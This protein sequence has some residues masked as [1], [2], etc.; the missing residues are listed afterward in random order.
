MLA[1]SATGLIVLGLTRPSAAF[2]TEVEASTDAQFYM[3]RSPYGDPIVRRRRYTQTLGLS[4]YDIQ[5]DAAL[6]GPRLSFRSRMRLDA[7]FGIEGA[8]SNPAR[9]DQFVPGAEQAPIDLMYAYLQ[10]EGYFGGWLGFRLGRQYVTDTLGFWSFDGGLVRL[11][12]PVYFAVEAYGGFE[13]RGGLPISTSRFE[14][15]GVFRGDRSDLE[16]GEYVGYLEESE[17]APALGFAVES[18]GVHFLQTRLSYRRVQNRDTVVVSPFP[19]AG[20]GLTTVGGDRVSSERLGY[21]LRV[22]EASLGAAGGSLVYDFYA[23]IVSEYEGSLDWYANAML[24][25]GAAYEYYEPTFDGDSV[26]N[27]FSHE[28]SSS[29]LGR[30]TLI[31]SR[32]IDVALT[33]GIEQFRTQ[34]DPATYDETAPVLDASTLTDVLGSLTG[35]YRWADGSVTLHAL[36]EAG[37]RGHRAGGDVTTKKLFGGGVYDMLVVSSLYDWSDALRPQRDAASFTYVLGGGMTPF[38]STRFG[39]EWEHTMNRLVGQRFRVLATLDLTVLK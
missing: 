39:V 19:D 34:G 33:G 26:F 14:G 28:G 18:T 7:D 1:G 24:T 11:D 9:R 27:W 6:S 31:F 37:E 25:L 5:G 10:G 38:E 4:V 36:G 35:R 21:G 8:E 13:Q 16:F 23:G 17:L 32:R 12:T 22:D 20:G 2:E 29:V 15:D 3:L 30:A